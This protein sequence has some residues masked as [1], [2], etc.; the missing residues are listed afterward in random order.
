MRNLFRN[1]VLSTLGSFKKIANGVH[2]L[3]SH[4]IA[5][6]DV[7]QEIFHDLLKKISSQAELINFEDA[8]DLIDK[9]QTQNKKCIAFSFDDG[10]EECYSKISPILKD[11][12]T[13][14]AYFINPGFIDGDEIYIN[15]FQQNKVHVN[16][17]P[18]TWKQ[19][20]ELHQQGFIIGNHT[21][22]HV[23]LVGLNS[24]E[25]H[26]QIITSKKLIETNLNTKCDYFAWT[27]GNMNDIDN[28]ALKTALNEHQFIFSCDNYTKYNSNNNPKIINRRHI[29]GNW[30]ITH[31]NYFLSKGKSY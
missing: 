9:K 24:D 4:Y 2:I 18:M 23:K 15:N 31:I 25:I 13:N 3:N 21:H 27:Y 10:F 5:R 14:A 17:P 12:N 11:F 8:V 26:H 30:P 29:E 28:N 6:E 7:S 19:I 16:K 1:T 20:K 22:D